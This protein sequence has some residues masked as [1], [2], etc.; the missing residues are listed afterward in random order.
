MVPDALSEI[1][2][3]SA[4][5]Q[6]KVG[7]TNTIDVACEVDWLLR[8][9]LEEEEVWELLRTHHVDAAVEHDSTAPDLD[10]HAT[11]SH[12]LASSQANNF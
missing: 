4:V 7:D 11:T 10:N 5:V 9:S 3:S 1:R 12:I 2:Q 6:M 8:G